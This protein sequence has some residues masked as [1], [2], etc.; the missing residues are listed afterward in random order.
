MRIKVLLVIISLGFIACKNETPR[1][2]VSFSKKTSLEKTIAINKRL[3]SEEKAMME[4]YMELDSTLSYINSNKG[5]WYAYRN[6][7]EKGNTPVK[8]DVVSFEQ[9]IIALDGTILYAK[10]DLGLRTYVVDKE[11]IIKG[12]KEGIKIMKEGEQVKFLFS[13]FVAY[14]MNG[15]NNQII[16]SNEPIVSEVHLVKINK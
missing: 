1:Y 15:D 16:G 5:F 2:P 13:S 8:G 6:K 11:H 3:F 12:L 4:K 7:E 10:K 9:E 14:R